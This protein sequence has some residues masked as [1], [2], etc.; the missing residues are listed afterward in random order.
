MLKALISKFRLSFGFVANLKQLCYNIICNICKSSLKIRYVYELYDESGTV[1]KLHDLKHVKNAT[2]AIFRIEVEADFADAN[3][4]LALTDRIPGTNARITR[5][6]NGSACLISFPSKSKVKRLIIPDGVEILSELAFQSSSL[7]ELIIPPSVTEISKRCFINSHVKKLS[8]SG[9]NNIKS[10]G[11]EA[12]EG[13]DI[14]RFVWPSKCETIPEG[15]F[16]DS[17]IEEISG[18]ENVKRV[19]GRAFTRTHD[20]RSIH[21]PEHCTVI[22]DACFYKSG[23]T[24]IKGIDGVREIGALAFAETRSL[25]DFFWPKKCTVISEKCFYAS[26]LAH[27]FGTINVEEI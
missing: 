1:L 9:E 23:I 7:T 17:R 3:E 22:P 11:D 25:R 6:G 12:F 10:I 16:D 20:L 14:C 15:C 2:A 26:K 21:W 24:E 18:L 8:F 13:S 4:E 5:L 19:E 27:L